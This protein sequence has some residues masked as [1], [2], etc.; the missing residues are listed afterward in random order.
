MNSSCPLNFKPIDSHLSRITSLLV[1]FLVLLYLWFNNIFILFFLAVDFMV[2]L[3]FINRVSL[4]TYGAKI[5]KKLLKLDNKL[6]DGGAKRLAGFFG[7]FFVMLLIIAHFFNIWT[8]SL[9]IAFI[10]I[11]CALLDVFIN[12]C[13]GCKI[14]FIIKKIYPNFM[15][16]L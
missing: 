12:F 4:L 9:I 13:I 16:N 5:I 14:Y 11:V 10:F 2:K 15:E 7:L 1:V 8:A 3:F 6:V